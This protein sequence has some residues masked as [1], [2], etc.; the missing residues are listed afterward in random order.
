M[1][2][3]HQE[4]KPCQQGDHEGCYNVLSE[5]PDDQCVCFQR[6]EAKHWTKRALD[7]ACGIE[8]EP[9]AEEEYYG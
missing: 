9:D 2:V 4:C 7:R 5:H 6:D 3:P 1:A 8:N